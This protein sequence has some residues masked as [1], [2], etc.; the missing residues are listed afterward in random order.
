[1]TK[2]ILQI[3]PQD[4][5]GGAERAA[6]DLHRGF[7]GRGLD[8]RLQV[9]RRLTFGPGIECIDLHDGEAGWTW[10]LALLDRVLAGMPCF[11]GRDRL[12]TLLSWLAIPRRLWDPLR[13]REDFNYPYTAHLADPRK[14]Q[15]EVICLHNLHGGYFDIRALPA[16]S[17]ALPVLW[18]LHDEWALTGHCA[19]AIDCQ[20]WQT[21]CGACPD[22][23]RAP[24]LRRDGTHENWRVKRDAYAKSCLHVVTPSSWLLDRVSR[25]ILRP[26]T[27]RVIRYGVN[28]GVFRPGDKQ[29][30]RE[31]LGL[32]PDRFV[33]VFSSVSGASPGSYKDFPTIREAAER[34]C[35]Q[36]GRKSVLLV[37]LGG[38]AQPVTDPSC[39][40][41]FPGT[42]RDPERVAAY[43]RAADVCLHAAHADNSPLAILEAQSCGT[44]VVATAVGG[45]PEELIDGATGWLVKRGDSAAMAA[46]I[47]QMIQDPMICRACAQQAIRHAAG[48]FSLERQVDDYLACFA[49]IESGRPARR[50]KG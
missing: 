49:E 16:L 17:Q 33:C 31:A 35:A 24:R 39:P 15:P 23:L 41:R 22:L 48:R 7:L 34:V 8:S 2:R 11:R 4:V 29:A 36:R 13:G 40:W 26:A 5:A 43:L 19:Y 47:L 45:I 25:S 1:M 12:R 21:G 20:R 18:T 44:P 38:P 32:P 50:P 37:C 28:Q 3:S 27:G 46:R 9:R 30:A 42:L 6:S 10:P 14:W